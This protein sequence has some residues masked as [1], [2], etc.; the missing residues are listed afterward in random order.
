MQGKEA[1][2]TGGLRRGP[3]LVT[4]FTLHR[5]RRLLVHIDPMSLDPRTHGDAIDGR[6]GRT[7]SAESA[8]HIAH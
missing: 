4:L 6:P 5:D 8:S 7:L 2:T 3:H 1:G